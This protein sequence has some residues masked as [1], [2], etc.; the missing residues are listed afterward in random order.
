[1]GSHHDSSREVAGGKELTLTRASSPEGA[2]LPFSEEVGQH[3]DA[4]I[5]KEE[6]KERLSAK[7]LDP[8]SQDSSRDVRFW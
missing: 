7:K 5:A 6:K 1:L 3:L 8:S 2:S 4:R